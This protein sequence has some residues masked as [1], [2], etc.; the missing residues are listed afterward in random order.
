MGKGRKPLP[1][2]TKLKRVPVNL[3][4]DIDDMIGKFKKEGQKEFSFANSRKFSFTLDFVKLGYGVKGAVFLS[5][6][7]VLHNSTKDKQGWFSMPVKEVEEATG[8]TQREQ[9]TVKKKLKE[10]GMLTNKLVGMPSVNYYR[11]DIKR[12]YN[13]LSK[14]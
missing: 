6:V 1:Y 2:R 9:Q 7:L 11:L 12:I 13:E 10:D 14:K 8:L 5:Q 4:G 3:F